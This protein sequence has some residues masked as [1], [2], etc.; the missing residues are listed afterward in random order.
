MV[1]HTFSF[2]QT[3]VIVGLAPKDNRPG[4]L[5]SIAAEGLKE[6]INCLSM[7]I[8]GFNCRFNDI[9]ESVNNDFNLD[10]LSNSL[11]PKRITHERRPLEKIQCRLEHNG[12]MPIGELCGIE[13][14]IRQVGNVL[15]ISKAD[16]C[17]NIQPVITSLK[18]NA[19]ILSQS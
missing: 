1:L 11:L 12:D 19:L 6:H 10:V 7:T 17:I 14:S 18:P 3:P 2:N 4:G 15:V 9:V 8:G 16:Q 13:A 5:V